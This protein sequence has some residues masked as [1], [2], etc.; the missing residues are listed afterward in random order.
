[1]FK[2]RSMIMNADTNGVTSTSSD[3]KRITP[4]RAFIR[5]TKL[6]ELSQFINVLLGSMSV[7]GPRPNTEK[8]VNSIQMKKCIF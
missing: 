2:V 6:D 7:V 5:K 4:I 8:T 3:D 1:M